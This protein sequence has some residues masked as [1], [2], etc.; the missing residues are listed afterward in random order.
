MKTTYLINKPQAGGSVQLSISNR[1]EWQAV[2]RANKQLPSEQRRYFILDYI[3]DGTD[4]DCMVM[5][6][7]IDVYRNWIREHMTSKRNREAGKGYQFLSVDAPVAD[8][9]GLGTLLDTISADSSVEEIVCGEMV[10]TDLQDALAAWK[11]WANDLLELYLQGQ[12]RTCSD[13]LAKQYGISQRMIRKYK[14]QFE[15]FVKNFFEEVPF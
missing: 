5:E 3:K 14:V 1:E 8:R 10:L 13:M 4:L 7:P 15:E 2:V 11:P 9:D 12:K 6:A